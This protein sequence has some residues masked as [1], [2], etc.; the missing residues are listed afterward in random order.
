MS[1]NVHGLAVELRC[2]L[3]GL[4]QV[5]NDLF[6]DLIDADWPAGVVPVFGSIDS[7]DVET[8]ARQISP[9]AECVSRFGDGAELW[10][11]SERVWLIDE[12][13]GICEI[14]LLKSS[15]KSWMLPEAD[16]EP[17]R[18]IEN[19]ILWPMAQILATRSLAVIPAPSLV[20]RGRGILAIAPFNLEP[21]LSIF[22][23]AGHGV[24]SQRWTAMREENGRFLMLHL[25]G[26][27][28]RSPIP[29]LRM[30]MNAESKPTIIENNWFDLTRDTSSRCNYAWC[31]A[32]LIVEPGRRAM[33]SLRPLTGASAAAMLKRAWPIPDINPSARH[34][35][36][37]TAISNKIPIFQVELSRD[38]RA[39]MRLLDQIPTESTSRSSL[40]ATIHTPS[41]TRVAS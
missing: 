9:Q 5:M 8:I 10:R 22:V 19:A 25:P 13:W 40:R 6:A 15:W 3:P 37:A 26:R 11:D 18:A 36:F 35:K 21:E 7:Y 41:T 4:R 28:E 30:K 33:A 39:L 16:G 34:A 1:I 29:Q 27:V 2:S 14:N 32:V 12:S 24:I 23:T 17:M 38:P 31:D 20:H